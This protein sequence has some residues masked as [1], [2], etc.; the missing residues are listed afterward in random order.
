MK[1]LFAYNIV[2][3]DN[4]YVSR[5][6]EITRS[7][8]NAEVVSSLEEFW[9]PT[10]QY[11]F[12]FINWPDYLFNWRKDINEKDVQNLKNIF[13]HFKNQKTCIITT[14]HDEYAHH[15]RSDFRDR[16]FDI[17]Y[18]K[19]DYL[20]HLGE[21]SLNKYKHDPAYAGINHRLVYHPLFKKFDFQ[22]D[23]QFVR[24]ELKIRKKDYYIIVPGGIRHQYEFD[25]VMKI[26]KQLN[27]PHKKIMFLRSTTIKKPPR[28]FNKE[29]ILF[30]IREL[31][32]KKIRKVYQYY[33]FMETSMLSKYFEAS[34]LVIL[35]RTDILNSGN[36][37][38]GTQFNKLIIGPDAG[39]IKEQL[40]KYEHIIID[41]SQI[42]NI[43]FDGL[44]KEKDS[45]K[46]RKKK[47]H[48]VQSDEV[49]KSQLKEIFDPSVSIPDRKT[50]G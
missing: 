48:E 27:L 40:E 35:P 2:E 42:E 49:I 36:V 47:I 31:A 18:I 29:F 44:I 5:M 39:N 32:D 10:R 14:L 26:F 16:I 1:I 13:N 4:E 22:L 12:V 24:K 25:Y 37:T 21:F 8:E 9:N 6:A 15:D 50:S 3:H 34:D 28:K 30:K 41:P 38:L 11:D 19:C 17:C 43:D 20:V 45:I 46:S 23:K 33:K 7:I